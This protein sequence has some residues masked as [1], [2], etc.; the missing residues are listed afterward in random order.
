[1][2]DV[3]ASIFS[4]TALLLTSRVDTRFD[5]EAM[6]YPKKRAPMNIDTVAKARSWM[7]CGVTSPNPTVSTVLTLQ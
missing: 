1:M 2:Y 3:T 6:I 5:M 7:V 4:P